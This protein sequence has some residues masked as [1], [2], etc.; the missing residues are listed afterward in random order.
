[1]IE[2]NE[3]DNQEAI[4]HLW[5]YVHLLWERRTVAIVTSIIVLSIGIFI[6]LMTPNKYTSACKIRLKQS[7][8]LQEVKVYSKRFYVNDYW[9]STEFE[10]LQSK[11]VVMEMLKTAKIDGVDLVTY[12]INK[13]EPSLSKNVCQFFGTTPS[14]IRSLL[15]GWLPKSDR[16]D[17][18][19]LTP[20]EIKAYQTMQVISKIQ[21]MIVLDISKDSAVI[22][23]V[24]SAIGNPEEAKVIANEL[25]L[26]YERFK[27]LDKMKSINKGL[28][29]IREQVREKS[30]VVSDLRRQLTAI[31]EKYHI[32]S[33]NEDPIKE[34]NP[35]TVSRTKTTLMNAKIEMLLNK[36]TWEKIQTMNDSELSEAFGVLVEDSMG[37]L[38]LKNDLNS[39]AVQFKLLE[40]DFGQSHPKVKRAKVELEE[41]SKQM[42]VRLNGIKSAMKLRY[43]KSITKYEGIKEEYD[44]LA[45][46]LSGEKSIHIQEFNKVASELIF[47]KDRLN[48]I[49]QSLSEK[50]VNQRL[51]RS[52]IEIISHAIT[53][54]TKSSPN[55]IKNFVVSVFLAFALSVGLVFL[56]DYLDNTPKSITQIERLT[57]MEVIATIPLLDQEELENG[58]EFVEVLNAISVILS[59]NSKVLSVQSSMPSEGKSTVCVKTAI[60]SGRAGNRVLV[61]DMDVRRPTVHD[62]LG[63]D[64][65]DGIAD[66][67]KVHSVEGIISKVKK[68]KYS[69]LSV[70]T[71]GVYN[72]GPPL[73][74]RLMKDIVTAFK[75]D[76][77]LII[78]DGPPVT[79]VNESLIIANASDDIIF[80]ISP[81]YSDLKLVKRAIGMLDGLDCHGAGVVVNQV[82][83]K[84]PLYHYNRLYDKYYS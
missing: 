24:V 71:A 4:V 25:P 70:L 53:P 5:D 15:L 68:T 55:H 63:V 9:I 52:V 17:M 1:M 61:I 44:Q 57:G 73:S 6:S 64:L 49:R 11:S 29:A 40:I 80:V 34:V 84:S 31:R 38:Q 69:G 23:I 26:A 54:K 28:D 82:S 36:K 46:E 8:E 56:L 33:S 76:F 58:R 32:T 51:P 21:S 39:A 77:D 50:E 81:S 18:E 67:L 79:V 60:E 45:N 35:E 62:I 37:Y 13:N 14:K 12:F 74:T 75:D 19:P 10:V 66:V 65:K 7:Y 43:E 48:S 2:Q 30:A 59:R 3:D 27:I 47:A 83:K 42:K 78:L 72:D 41:L 16:K 22:N 20:E